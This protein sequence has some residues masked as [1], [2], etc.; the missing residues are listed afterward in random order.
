MPPKAITWRSIALG[1]LGV[2]FI[3][4]VTPFNNHVLANTD[5]VSSYLPT[6]L[7]LFF[8][9][10]IVLVNAPLN[11][12][13]PRHA[14]STGE[15][16]IALSMVLVG[17]ALPFTGLM[18]YLP[19]HLTG[20]FYQA[21]QRA[22]YAHVLRDAHLS[23]WLFPTMGT[24]D[25]ALRGTD[26]VVQDYVGRA[27]VTQDTFLAH[28]HAVP[29][30]AW[31]IPAATWGIFL[32]GLFGSI[33]CMMVIF[34]RQWVENERLQF[35]L[36]TVFMSLIES[37]PPGRSLNRLFSN[38]IFW[39]GFAGVFTLHLLSGL[40]VYFPRNFPPIPLSYNLSTILTEEPWRYVEWDVKFQR[41]YFTIIGLMI[42][43]QTRT[44][45]SMWFVFVI[46]QVARML[47]GMRQTDISTPMQFDQLFGA[48]LVFAT[49]IL[50][51][52]RQ[53]LAA[54]LR[55]MFF[56][57]REGDPQGRYLPYQF[58]GWSFIACQLLLVI[59]LWLA[60]SAFG[61]AMII[62]GMLSLLFMV[63]AK[64]V[65]DTGMIYALIPVPVSHPFDLAA[66][67]MPQLHR[68]S[69]GSYF[70]ASLFSGIL[71]HDLRQSL[72]PYAQH[73]L[74][75]ADR[76]GYDRIRN[77]RKAIGVIGVIV[78]ALAVAYLVSGASTLYV[79]YNY[80]AT[81]DRS[82]ASPINWWGSQGMVQMVVMDPSVRY[83]NGLS[84]P[85]HNRWLHVGIGAVITA[86]L[87]V[88]RLTVANWPI[89]PVGFLLAYTWGLRQIWFSIFL[90]WIAKVLIV[91]FGGSRMFMASQPLFIGLIMGEVLAAAWWLSVSLVLAAMGLEYRAIVLL[92]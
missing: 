72:P 63:L 64:I 9:L 68:A 15:L 67:T 29:W 49:M 12:F 51:V 26:P 3:N 60:G 23:S 52:A 18:R 48:V 55:Q 16:G 44:A 86:V 6:G 37:P 31:L 11:R 74:V 83:A 35:P 28:W 47:A 27:I 14:L 13:A 79:E 91:R 89:H 56:R 70:F 25:V 33:L 36:G 87:G 32:V 80:A 54:V 39:I 90:G 88:T 19:G 81:L 1:L 71:T 5:M 78:L 66:A 22:E 43:V 77:W 84:T 69:T 65:A 50:W 40:S 8:C 34:R 85:A 42:F 73:A 41:I 38:R 24:E 45:F 58:A 2:I 76:S 17:C 20:L 10:F 59:W 53:H 7:L 21:S 57:P 30:H 61:S 46:I 62:V 92:P 75:V 4:A 82:N